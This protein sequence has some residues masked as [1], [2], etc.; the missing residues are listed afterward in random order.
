MGFSVQSVEYMTNTWAQSSG[1]RALGRTGNSNYWTRI[2]IRTDSSGSTGASIYLDIE[3]YGGYG[4]Q[5][6]SAGAQAVISTSSSPSS[7]V[8]TNA[9]LPARQYSSTTSRWIYSGSVPANLA[10]NTTY[11]IIITPCWTAADTF[12]RYVHSTPTAS[13]TGDWPNYTLTISAGVGSSAGV[14]RTAS[15]AGADTGVLASGDRIFNGDTLIFTYSTDTGYT[16]AAHTVNGATQSSGH[17]WTVSSDAAVVTTATPT[18]YVLDLQPGTGTVISVS[19]TGSPIGGGASGILNDGD[20]IY[21]NDVLTIVF[22]PQTGYTITATSVTGAVQSGD[23]WAAGANDVTAAASADP[24]EHTLVISEDTGAIISV[25]RTASPVGGGATGPLSDGAVVYYSDELLVAFSA[26]SGYVVTTSTINGVAVQSGSYA[27]PDAD[28]E[29]EET[30]TAY[31]ALSVQTNTGAVVTVSRTASP[32][33][34]GAVEQLVDGATIY[35]GDAL[36]I[37]FTLVTGY[38]YTSKTINDE[39]VSGGSATRTVFSSITVVGFAAVLSYLLALDPGVGTAISVERMSSPLQGADL[40]LLDNGAAIYYSDTLRVVFSAEDGYTIATR[41]INGA[42]AAGTVDLTVVSSV[43]CAATATLN[44]YYLRVVRSSSGVSGTV[45]RVSSQHTT[46]GQIYNGAEIYYG[47]VLAVRYQIATGYTLEEATIN[48]EDFVSGKQLTVVGDVAV[49]VLAKA[50]G[51]VYIG[52]EPY[53][54]VVGNG[55]TYDRYLAKIGDGSI[56]DDY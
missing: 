21:Y 41:T 27:A 6:Y 33:G 34:H 32:S 14:E 18:P 2:T 48:G 5:Y 8:G 12:A 1:S 56:Y 49:V 15:S 16:I 52:N 19:R 55:S 3:G 53:I 54:P 23:S 38:K 39:A 20:T 29:I 17:S 43:A 26:G 10:A 31:F 11:Y 25:S 46:S 45:L 22:S 44:V 50:S 13:S 42:A 51:F 37:S 30:T 28:V 35:D 4:N 7:Y 40:G 36:S 9:N 47:D 24:T